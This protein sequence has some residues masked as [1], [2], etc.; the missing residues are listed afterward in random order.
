VQVGGLGMLDKAYE[1]NVRCTIYDKCA[2]IVSC[3]LLRMKVGRG[4]HSDSSERKKKEIER[5]PAV[6]HRLQK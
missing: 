2:Y 1:I 4:F 3:L 5:F 6:P